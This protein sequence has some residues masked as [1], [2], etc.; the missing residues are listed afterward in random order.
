MGSVD[1]YEKLNRIGEGTYGIVYRAKH[2]Q[3]GSIVALKRIRMDN[4][5]EGFPLSSLREISILRN[6]CHV[7]VVKVLD[8]V[9]GSKIQD[10]FLL[11]EYC[12]QDM[13]KL[14]DTAIARHDLSRVFQPS[15]VKCLMNQLLAGVAYL[16]DSFI[17]HRSFLIYKAISNSLIYC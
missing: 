10:V 3:S 11:M 17:I 2:R 1:A 9:V 7:N 16:H 6:L 4:I 13:A 12:E 5:D 14:M 8:V 15:Q